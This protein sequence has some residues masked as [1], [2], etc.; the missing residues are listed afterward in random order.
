MT[1]PE[2]TPARRNAFFFRQAITI[3]SLAITLALAVLGGVFHL[4]DRV[5][6][7]EIKV[8]QHDQAIQALPEINRRLAHIEGALGIGDI[9]KKG[10]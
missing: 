1:Q 7:V 6:T 5:T 2:A 8:A 4:L 10:R 9:P 3:L